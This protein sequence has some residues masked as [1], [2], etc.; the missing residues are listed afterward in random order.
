MNAQAPAAHPGTAVT[1]RDGDHHIRT[2]ALARAA[3]ARYAADSQ[4]AAQRSKDAIRDLRDRQ[5]RL[6]CAAQRLA[7]IRDTTRARLA[8]IATGRA[9]PPATT[10]TSKADPPASSGPA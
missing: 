4:A 10:E 1:G 8:A 3:A 5:R 2:A 9:Q 7:A 6:R